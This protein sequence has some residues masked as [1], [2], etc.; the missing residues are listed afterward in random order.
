MTFKDEL[1]AIRGECDAMHR[2]A[3][4]VRRGLERPKPTRTFPAGLAG[5]HPV[6][7]FPG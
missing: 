1:P 3:E 6:S 2:R 5:P 7:A 4:E